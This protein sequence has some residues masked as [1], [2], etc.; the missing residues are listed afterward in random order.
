MI[1]SHTYVYYTAYTMN[2]TIWISADTVALHFLKRHNQ[3]KIISQNKI[4]DFLMIL[5]WF[6]SL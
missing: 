2:Q 6:V 1:Y 5:A 4:T 3:A